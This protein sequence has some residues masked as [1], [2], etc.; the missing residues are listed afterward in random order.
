MDCGTSGERWIMGFR[1]TGLAAGKHEQGKV[2]V[3]SVTPTSSNAAPWIFV[4]DGGSAFF[5][6]VLDDLWAEVEE[7]LLIPG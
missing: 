2:L 3:I 5:D 7:L 4:D 1:S 6:P